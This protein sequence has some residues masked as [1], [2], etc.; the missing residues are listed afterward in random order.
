MRSIRFGICRRALC[1]AR[2]HTATLAGISGSK[3]DGAFS[4]V[5][6]GGY[7]DDKD[8]GETL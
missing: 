3:N 5:V 6:S 7:E 8:D 4:I 1:N 2:V